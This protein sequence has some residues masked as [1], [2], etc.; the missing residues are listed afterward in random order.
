MI[1]LILKFLSGKNRNLIFMIHNLKINKTGE[2]NEI[3]N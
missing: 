2:L 1:I 3:R